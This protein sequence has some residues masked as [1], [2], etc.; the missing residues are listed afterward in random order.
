VSR[1]SDGSVH[2][3]GYVFLIC[4]FKHDAWCDSKEIADGAKYLYLVTRLTPTITIK[5]H[6]NDNAADLFQ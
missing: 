4:N 2:A 6:T 5:D 3:L 1:I